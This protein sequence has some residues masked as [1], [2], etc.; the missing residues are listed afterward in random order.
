MDI[1]KTLIILINFIMLV[2]VGTVGYATIL[3]VKLLDGL[4]MTIISVSTVGY[5]E[6]APMN[7]AAKIFTILII[8]W[9]IGIVGYTFTNLVVMF[10]D[11]RIKE[12]WRH[13]VMDGRISKLKNHIIICGAGRKGEVIIEQFFKENVEFVVIEENEDKYFNLIDKGIMAIHGD[14]TDD[15]ML[16]KAQIK[17]AFGLISSLPTDMDNIMTVLSARQ[18]N[19]EMYII[20]SAVDNSAPKKLLKAGANRVISSSL[21]SGNRMAALM[22]RPTVISFLDLVN[23]VGDIELELQDVVVNKGSYLYN[24]SLKEAQ[25]PNKTGLTVLAVKIA[26]ERDIRFNLNPDRKI[27]D[28]DTLLIL[29]TKDQVQSLRELAGDDGHR[30]FNAIN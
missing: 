22:L 15:D 10:V 13:R 25:I 28:N 19:K 9:G 26:N 27:M 4:Y 30:V 12:L 1:R 23:N 11:G 6:I 20:S 8:L 29:G 5:S 3:G 18:L 7:D 21:I 2:V 14:A 17:T 24:I 16:E